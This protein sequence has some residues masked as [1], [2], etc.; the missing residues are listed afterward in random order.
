MDHK[1]QKISR[2]DGQAEQEKHQRVGEEGEET[3]QQIDL[4]L[5]PFRQAESTPEV[6]EDRARAHDRQDA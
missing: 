4:F 3:P 1:A 5:C 6:A 2:D